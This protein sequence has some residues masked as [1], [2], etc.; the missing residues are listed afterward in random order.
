MAEFS[1]DVAKL[2]RW[3]ADRL[4]PRRDVA[5]TEWERL[6][7]GH[8]NDTFF[9]SLTWAKDDEGSTGNSYVVR[10]DIVHGIMEPY[11]IP[12]EF[13]LLRALNNTNVRAPKVYWLEEDP[14]ILGA[15]FYVMERCTGQQ[16]P[17]LW[18]QRG[19][20]FEASPAER[21]RLQCKYL[22]QLIAVHLVDWRALGLE[23]MG[24]PLGFD[25]GG[26]PRDGTTDCAYRAIEEW[27]QKALRNQLEPEPLFV[28]PVEWLRRNMP[29]TERVT[30]TMGDCKL[31]NF[32]F[33][34]GEV[35]G[36]FD[37]EW[38]R[39][40]D[41][42]WDLAWSGFF[43]T[44]PGY[45]LEGMMDP[46]E[47]SK[48]YEEQSGIPVNMQNVRFWAVI[49]QLKACSFYPGMAR[50]FEQEKSHDLRYGGMGYLSHQSLVGLNQ[51]CGL[52]VTEAQPT[53][54]RNA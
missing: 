38:A 17:D 9:V 15:T 46:V 24:E 50:V 28:E 18:T 53:A 7:F 5:I 4:A 41:P 34:D 37:W 16:P 40:S 13:R 27:E 44:R 49:G 52:S 43:G 33:R 42:M 35:S 26:P 48:Y 54:L 47:A 36:I 21:R 19:F 45:L 1:I 39:L 12:K 32:M 29:I 51:A 10:R 11:D 25:F 6:P 14:S 2:E 31:S 22:D 23:E 30:L 20:L 8:S 3:F